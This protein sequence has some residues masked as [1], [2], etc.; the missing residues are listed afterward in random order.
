MTQTPPQ[1]DPIAPATP[2]SPV[3]AL[4][5]GLAEEQADFEAHDREE[6][7]L[8][9]LRSEAVA[10]RVGRQPGVPSVEPTDG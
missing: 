6:A 7:E 4:R 9:N 8:E 3:E 2:A 10:K 1:P 5:A